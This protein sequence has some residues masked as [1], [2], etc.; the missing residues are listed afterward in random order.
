M[1]KVFFGFA[2]ADSMFASDCLVRRQ[3]L[4]AD[5]AKKIIEQGVESC[6]NSSH[7][8]TIVA[9]NERFGIEVA[10]PTTPPRVTLNAGDSL[11]VMGVRGLPRL[12]ENRHYTT[13]EIADASFSFAI[14][15]VIE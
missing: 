9:M 11:I 15:T 4:T 7:E 1:N 14:Y 13:E 12:T 10:I 3:V 5:E 6:L 8:A 2:L